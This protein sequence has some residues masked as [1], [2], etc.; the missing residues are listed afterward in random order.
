MLHLGICKSHGE[1]WTAGDNVKLVSHSL[2]NLET[3][4]KPVVANALAVQT[5]NCTSEVFS[6]VGNF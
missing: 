2:N 6:R 3:F 1:L 5:V 4:V